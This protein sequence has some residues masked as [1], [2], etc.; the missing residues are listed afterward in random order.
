MR[1]I[2][3]KIYIKKVA[4][5]ENGRIFNKYQLCVPYKGDKKECKCQFFT[6]GSWGLCDWILNKD[7]DQYMDISSYYEHNK[8]KY[9]KLERL[10]ED[11]ESVAE[12]L[13]KDYVKDVS[14]LFSYEY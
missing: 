5:I 12:Q 14:K 2:V 13:I 4:C 1:A 8:H 9:G 10:A 6:G 3:G 7:L 11:K